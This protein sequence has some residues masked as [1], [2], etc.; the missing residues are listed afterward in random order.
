MPVVVRLVL[1]AVLLVQLF[2]TRD[3]VLQ[4]GGRRRQIDD[5][6]LDLGPQEMVRTGGPEVGE[7]RELLASGECED[8]GRVVEVADLRPVG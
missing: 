8:D 4:R 6:R 3:D 1:G 2:E 7:S 5:Q